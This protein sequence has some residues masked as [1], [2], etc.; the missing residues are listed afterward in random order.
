MLRIFITG[1]NHIGLKYANH[2]ESGQLVEERISAFA[3]MVEKANQEQCDLFVI[4]GDLFDNQYGIQK[5]DV[6]R[7]IDYLTGWRVSK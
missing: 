7:V 2:E 5:R 4:T 1:D 3:P 6:K